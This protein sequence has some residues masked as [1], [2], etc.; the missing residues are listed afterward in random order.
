MMQTTLLRFSCTQASTPEPCQASS[1]KRQK[2][3]TTPGDK[4]YQQQVAHTRNQFPVFHNRPCMLPTLVPTPCTT[5]CPLTR[6][7]SPRPMYLRASRICF[8]FSVVCSRNTDSDA[9][10]RTKNAFCNDLASGKTGVQ[11]NLVRTFSSYLRI[12]KLLGKSIVQTSFF[13]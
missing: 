13:R 5:I 8:F 2:P 10:W 4:H 12:E 9:G 6:Y 1:R 3:T 11:Q 7:L